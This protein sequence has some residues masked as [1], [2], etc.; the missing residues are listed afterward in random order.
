M[1]VPAP[2]DWEQAN[3]QY[4][5]ARLEQVRRAL[6]QA[7]GA[8]ADGPHADEEEPDIAALPT[9]KHAM[10]AAL[11]TLG[12]LFDLSSFERDILLLCA[13]VELDSEFMQLCAT[14]QGDQQ[15]AYPTFRLALSVLPNA[16]WSA[17][18]PEAPLRRWRLLIVEPGQTLTLS[19]LRID[20]R[21][22]HYLIGMSYLDRQLTGLVQPLTETARL[23]PSHQKIAQELIAA[24]ASS[25]ES[26][27]LPVVQLCGS[28]LTTICMIAVA[29]CS[30]LEHEVMMLPALALP[31]SP[32]EL[33]NLRL[34]WERE[35]A[36]SKCALLL[37]CTGV[38]SS[39]PARDYAL[40]HW[41]E[42]N[43]C[44]LIIASRERRLA[45]RRPLVSFD[46]QKPAADEQLLIW[47]AG[48]GEQAAALNGQLARLTTCFHLNESA[49]E[50]VCTALRGQ[51]ALAEQDHTEQRTGDLLWDLCRAQARPR[52]DHLALRIE[53]VAG[54]D[55]LII[56]EAQRTILR[57]IA[58]Q[59]RQQARVYDTWGF[60]SKGTRGLGI[61]ALFAG[62]SGTGK[63]MAA[64]VL[65][66]EL[67]LDLYQIDLSMVISKYI[68]ET[69]KNLSR[70]FES[71]E[72]SGVI[73]L[74]DEADALFGKRTEIKDSHDRYANV[75]ISYLLQR[76]EAYR[77]LAILTT[78][79]KDALDTAFLRRIRFIVQFP[80]PDV[81]QRAAIWQRIFPAA[82]PTEGL[83][84]QKLAQLNIAGGHIRAIALNAAFMAA[85]GGE[86]V[87]MQH[88]LQAARYEYAKMEKTLTST[89]TRGWA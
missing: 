55:D 43:S 10:P 49:I 12:S 26:D 84:M 6:K 34:L 78:N 56:S 20:E 64:E 47:Q 17:L 14:L 23:V 68:G 42:A 33:E 32:A 57:H 37:D 8:A 24:W 3:K 51:L 67:H 38:E 54:W 48:L 73:L 85:D 86:P 66:R 71:A 59:M 39:D 74:F 44:P 31:T 69:E 7:S 58:M 19:P 83:D 41:I 21:I 60:R 63:T 27:Q 75:E 50:A 35:A 79:M 25:G 9:M 46:V 77:G 80:F 18:S 70:I 22:L 2:D 1:I 61:S 5:M 30:T 87:R 52:L 13:G 4:F 53:P 89:E 16:Y 88:V 40:I 65:A 81:E 29:A 72:D 36:L 15:H 76:M 28:D 11:D 45:P 82:T 62:A